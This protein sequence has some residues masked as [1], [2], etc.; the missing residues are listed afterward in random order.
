[1]TLTR[2]PTRV[3]A[4]ASSTITTTVQNELDSFSN[5]SPTLSASAVY[6]VEAESSAVTTVGTWSTYNE[7]ACSASNGQVI[8]SGNADD[9][10]SYTFTGS[11]VTVL[12][13]KQWNTG[14]M[15]VL[16]DGSLQQRVDTYCCVPPP[17]PPPNKQC[18]QAVVVS[19]LPWGP[20]TVEAVVVG[21][22]NPSSD[23]NSIVVDAFVV[24]TDIST[25]CEDA[26]EPDNDSTTAVTVTVPGS[27][28]H[29]FDF[30]G[31]QDWVKFWA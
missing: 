8:Y 4:D 27:T 24:T 6:T 21:D 11:Q 31:D 19:D 12:Y 1:V 26:Y 2:S 30:A 9:K 10:V 18:Q 20:H 3:L 16:V 28:S 22:K 13:Q 15:D 23:G 17:A 25:G 7:T 14:F 5:G 29:N